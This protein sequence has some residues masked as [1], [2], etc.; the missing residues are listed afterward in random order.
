MR[1]DQISDLVEQ[2]VIT[3][4]RMLGLGVSPGIAIGPAHIAEGDDIQVRESHLRQTEIEVER[5]RFAEAV[6]VSLR[7]LRKLK[8]KT[9]GL[10]ESAA[11]EV[12]YLLDAHLAMLSNSRLVRGVDHRIIRA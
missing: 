8:V 6:S 1:S 2:A 5:G 12:G 4:R 3:E 11:E 9:A 10:P 7:Q